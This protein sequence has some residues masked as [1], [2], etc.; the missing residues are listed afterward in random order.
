MA[1]TTVVSVWYEK[2][3]SKKVQGNREKIEKYLKEGFFIQ[4]HRNGNWVLVKTARV[5]VTLTN[6]DKTETF[7]MK[8]DICDYY[9]KKVISQNLVEK[10]REDV[11]AEIITLILDPR[12]GYAFN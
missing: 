4:E 9:G 12:G 10:F 11:A 6:G 3:D 2:G 8:E 1:E 5:N 7:N